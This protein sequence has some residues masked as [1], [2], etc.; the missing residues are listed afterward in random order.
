MG[1]SRDLLSEGLRRLLVNACYWALSMEDQIPSASEVDIVGKYEPT[2]FGF[3]KNTPRVCDPPIYERSSC[4]A[5]VAT[6]VTA[7][8]V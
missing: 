2:P 5:L 4:P 6:L 3:G 8:G 1:A 7:W